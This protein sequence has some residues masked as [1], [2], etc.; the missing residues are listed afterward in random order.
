MV[1][2]IERINSLKMLIKRIGGGVLY[3]FTLVIC[4]DGMESAFFDVKALIIANLI[5]LGMMLLGGCNIPLMIKSQFSNNITSE[6]LS[7]AITD[8]GH[9]RRYFLIGGTACALIG[10]AM[11]ISDL[12][13]PSK[14]GPGMAT[15]LLG[16]L[17]A[18]MY[19]YGFALPCQ[20]YLKD[21]GKLPLDH[22]E[23]SEVVIVSTFTLSLILGML[24]I[25]LLSF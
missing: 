17:Y 11:T 20:V 6:E 7:K 10:I 24:S 3:L 15:V 5:P 18:I 23:T 14:I 9:A 12:S 1:P 22:N 25:L 8:W 4:M 2:V 16:V 13:D 19:S 21:R